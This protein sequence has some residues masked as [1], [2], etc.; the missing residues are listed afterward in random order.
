MD[1]KTLIT[2]EYEKVLEKL[3]EYADFSLS[4]K[5]ALS[6]K[7]V[8]D[9]FRSKKLVST[10]SEARLLLSL[11]TDISIGSARDIRS[12]VDL[13]SRNGILEPVELLEIRDTLIS[14]RD[15]HRD[16]NKYIDK[17]PNLAEVGLNLTPPGGLIDAINNVISDR[18]EILDQASSRLATTRKEI[19]TCRSRLVDRLQKLISNAH[20]VPMLQEQIITQRNDRYV[21][22]LKAE[23]KGRIKGIVHDQSSS[24]ATLFIEP[25]HIVEINNEL[26]ELQLTERNEEQR[27]LAMLSAQIGREASVI[28]DLVQSVAEFDLALMC[29]KYADDIDAVEPILE[30]FKPLKNTHPGSMICFKKA[31]HPLI[32]PAKV[33]PIDIELERDVFS[34][35][36]TGPN[37]GGKTVTLK[38]IGLL[39][40]MAQS[41]LH[42]PAE[43]GSKFTVFDN[44]FADIG[45]E[46]SIEQSLSTFSGHISNIVRIIKNCDSHSLILLDELGA[47]TDPQEGATLAQAIL[48]H[49]VEMP[50]TCFIATHYPELK[51]FAHSTPGI[52]NASL[53]FNP[54]TL[55]PTYHLTIGLPG[56][57]NALLIA[58]RLGLSE[59][60]LTDARQG[61]NPDD[62]KAE[63]LL[64]DIHK[65]RERAFKE[66][67]RAKSERL[68]VEMLRA[69]LEERLSKIEDE[70]LLILETAQSSAEDSVADL[71]DEIKKIRKSLPGIK[72]PDEELKKIKSQVKIV[73]KSL[74]D[75]INAQVHEDVETSP[76]I[77]G[78]KVQVRKLGLKGKIISIENDELE[79][80]AGSLRI[81]VN[82]SDI[83]HPSSE[84]SPKPTNNF[85][86]HTPN[87]RSSSPT[88]IHPS[89]GVEISLRGMR[90][91][92]A[93]DVLEKHIEN[94]YLAGVPFIRVV[95]GKGTGRLRQ[96]VQ[97]VL[98]KSEYIKSWETANESEGGT[99]ATIGH[100]IND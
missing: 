51:I 87:R 92:E 40:L 74:Q 83:T 23:F 49:F 10:T 6:K 22:P 32:D 44:I 45:D 4:A 59:E 88:L 13:A 46:Q 85:R 43:S 30:A 38:M 79:I 73:E 71:K 80:L 60:I 34:L 28:N 91:D 16:F 26:Q 48:A 12:I 3:A 56:R 15:L 47:G 27:I 89:P 86:N 75:K 55:R 24:G 65:Q 62:L 31:R 37:T 53:E 2:L 64:D 61:I 95:H 8:S 67:D 94:A 84:H 25:E 41:G 78:D 42:I 66:Y 76:L 17:L 20:Y 98:K 52:V 68:A 54:K 90:V 82:T 93:L 70:R 19:K 11:N 35:V 39:V 29:A 33:V 97:E 100:L 5:L 58:K 99:G 77:I 69:E 96:A 18:G 1:R 72:K 14:S 50:V 57:S 9:L 81:K 63:D 7:P 36:I 21:I